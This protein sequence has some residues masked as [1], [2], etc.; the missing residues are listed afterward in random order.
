[1]AVAV[2]LSVAAVALVGID[3]QLL[4]KTQAVAQRQ[5]VPYL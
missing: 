1:V 2:V 3:V 4:A 5:K